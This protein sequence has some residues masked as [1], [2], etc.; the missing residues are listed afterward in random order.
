MSLIDIDGALIQAYIDLGI[1]LATAYENEEFTPPTTG[2]DWAAVSIVPASIDYNSLGENG[3]DLHTGFMQVDFNTK[4]GT[5]RAALI[6]YAQTLR[7]GF[8]GGK[9]YTHNSQNVRIDTVERSSVR[10]VDGWMR[11]SITVNWEATTIRPTI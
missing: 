2:P 11:I 6:G 4:H 1:G 3:E 8:I 5:G 10:E 7:D 9:G